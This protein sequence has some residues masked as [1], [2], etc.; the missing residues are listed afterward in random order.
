MRSKTVSIWFAGVTALAIAATGCTSGGGGDAASA[1]EDAAGNAAP[2]APAR[3]YDCRPA[4]AAAPAP[5]APVDPAAVYSASSNEPGD[6]LPGNTGFDRNENH[7][8]GMLFRGLVDY[9]PASGAPVPAMMAA[10]TTTDARTYTISIA[11]GWTFHDGTPVTAK[12]YADAWTWA[13]D[14]ANEAAGAEVLAEVGTVKAADPATLVVTLDEPDSS[15]PAQLGLAAFSPLPEVFFAD[16]ARFGREPVGNGPFRMDPQGGW[17]P[18]TSLSLVR[19][20]AYAGPDKAQAA[21]VRLEFGSDA[22]LR[23]PLDV[24]SR[25]PQPQPGREV[26]VPGGTVV[27]QTLSTSEL[28]YFPMDD[29]AWSAPEAAKVRQ[30]LSLAINREAIVREMFPGG[31]WR[32]ATDWLAAGVPGGNNACGELCAYD[33]ERARQLV[34]EGGGVPG[35]TVT[36]TY[37]QDGG[38]E[39]VF[40]AICNSINTA[41]GAAVCVPAPVAEFGELRR[42]INAREPAGMFRGGWT[43]DYPS[44]RN[45]LD[46]MFRGD[47]KANDSAYRNGLFDESVTQARTS[48]DP[49]KAARFWSD[50]QAQL[51]IDMPALPLWS[52]GTTIAS[53]PTIANLAADRFGTP[54]W[55]RIGVKAGTAP[56]A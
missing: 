40:K 55:T 24:I 17:R 12:S 26:S 4:A 41:L 33:P 9:D 43:A 44:P 53:A 37:A 2:S 11:S 31:A 23:G 54:V 14:P 39:K 50:A 56:G 42:R 30:G 28:L 7:A 34:A 45:F 49:Q 38:R 16:P 46:L 47:S 35:G 52:Y 25:V 15:F 19:N 1:A 51:A 36:L 3:P 20:D 5:G 13:L 29:P 18:G 8:V 32:P 6:L 10:C 27:H 22:A 21:G 48:A